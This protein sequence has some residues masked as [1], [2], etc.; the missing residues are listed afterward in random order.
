MNLTRLNPTAG[1]RGLKGSP[2]SQVRAFRDALL[3]RG[4]NHGAPNPRTRDRRSMRS[5]SRSDIART[6]CNSVALGSVQQCCNWVAT[7]LG[8]ELRPTERM[9]L[10][11]RSAPA[12]PCSGVRPFVPSARDLHR[13]RLS[14]EEK[15]GSLRIL[16]TYGSKSGGTEGLAQMLAEGLRA[17]RH[18]VDVLAPR[19]VDA[20]DPYDAVIVGGALYAHRW[21]RAARRFVK[22]HAADLRR[23]PTYLFSSGPLDD[24]A[25]TGDI[26]P[27]VGVVALMRL[28]GARSHITF[29][30]RLLQDAG[31]FPARAM[32]K[33]RS[34][35]LA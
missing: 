5:A 13:S 12:S 2:P 17:E 15:G 7:H 4:A 6:V 18:E 34:G 9:C 28:V 27:V 30:G 31:G 21:H 33:T 23:R 11:S 10:M 26:P 16:I 32:A 25:S 29:G 8:I 3:D 22:R 14:L 20:L 35:R 24:T 19:D 1:D